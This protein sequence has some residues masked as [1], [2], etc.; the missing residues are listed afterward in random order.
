MRRIACY[1]PRNSLSDSSNG[2]YIGKNK[3]T[4]EGNFTETKAC[5]ILSRLKA[6]TAARI[7]LDNW[8]KCPFN[9]ATKHELVAEPCQLSAATQSNSTNLAPGGLKERPLRSFPR[10]L[11]S[12]P[13]S[14]FHSPPRRKH[15]SKGLE[16]WF[17]RL[18]IITKLARQGPF[19]TGGQHTTSGAEETANRCVHHRWRPPG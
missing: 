18:R 7:R 4:L 1:S 6:S 9:V 12:V 15:E 14:F 5:G 16:R 2:V 11:S 10:H 19:G 17:T 8:L 13:T 3:K